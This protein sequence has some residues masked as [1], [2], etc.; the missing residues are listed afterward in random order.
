MATLLWIIG[1]GLVAAGAALLI[2]FMMWCRTEEAVAQE[3]SALAQLR[4]ALAAQRQSLERSVEEVRAT[5][6]REAFDGFIEDFRVEQRH[7]VRRSKMLF[8]TR[9]TLVVQERILFRN[10][11]LSDWVEHKMTLEE[12]AA[13][14]GVGP[15]VTMQ[16]AEPRV[17]P[18]P[19][20]RARQL[21]V[22]DGE[23]FG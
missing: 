12:S 23:V 21:L 19:T 3:R 16:T 22:G 20:P 18:R 14:Q 15:E 17:L 11:P 10:L 4:S 1:P 13:S 5:V 6:K 8:M 2:C 9:K 7:Y